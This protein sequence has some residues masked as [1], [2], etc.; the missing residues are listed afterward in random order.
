VFG[1]SILPLPGV[2]HAFLPFLKNLR[3]PSRAI[4]F[5]YLFLA[6]AV[7]QAMVF[8]SHRLAM[9][10]IRKYLTLG[11]ICAL[12]VVD[13]WPAKIDTTPI[14]CT[15]GDAVIRDDPETDFGVLNLPVGLLNLPGGYIPGNASM[16]EQVCHHRPIVIANTSHEETQSLSA[17]LE[18]KDLWLQRKQLIDSKVKYIVLRRK[19][20]AVYR[21]TK[22]E[23]GE[24]DAYSQTYTAV[25][26]D[27]EVLI[28]RVY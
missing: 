10:P 12:I 28:F 26:E 25:Y 7:A 15:P 13:F 8:L 1:Q 19:D 27:A 4:V 18:V 3:T 16:A 17:R 11:A 24:R 22:K 9:Q 23:N 6:I 21:W 14:S 5:V 2:L 20:D